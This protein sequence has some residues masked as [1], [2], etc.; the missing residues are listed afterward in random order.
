MQKCQLHEPGLQ[1]Q[2]LVA[3]AC[4][5]GILGLLCSWHI[6][7]SIS[8]SQDLNYTWKGPCADGI[9]PGPCCHLRAI[10]KEAKIS[11][12]KFCIR[13]MPLTGILGP[14]PLPL[15]VS[16]V[17]CGKQA[18]CT[19]SAGPC[20]TPS[21]HRPQSTTLTINWNL[22]CCN[23]N[24]PFFFISLVYFDPVKRWQPTIQRQLHNIHQN[25]T[26]MLSKLESSSLQIKELIDE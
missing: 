2:I 12:R 3:I 11:Q 26:G 7:T 22:W 16:Q 9:M 23:Q 6:L 18:S 13:R 5:V 14:K 20:D 21:N 25:P 15:F 4:G 24:K 19:T 10:E 1:V 8:H 17:L